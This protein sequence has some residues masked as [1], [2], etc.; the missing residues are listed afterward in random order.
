MSPQRQHLKVPRLWLT[1]RTIHYSWNAKEL[2]RASGWKVVRR[3]KTKDLDENSRSPLL[4]TTKALVE[5]EIFKKDRHQVPSQW[6]IQ[7]STNL[8]LELR[9]TD[10]FKLVSGRDLATEEGNFPTN[11]K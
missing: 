10:D 3:F 9:P 11:S 1:R 5:N 7:L 2:V 4:T 8:N 6:G